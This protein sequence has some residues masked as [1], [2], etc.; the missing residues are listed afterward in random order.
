M[1]NLLV[2]LS[3]LVSID[4]RTSMGVASDAAQRQLIQHTRERLGRYVLMAMELAVL[5]P[6]GHMDTPEGRACLDR[7]GLL[8]PGEWEAMVAGDRHTT[9]LCWVQMICV[10][11]RRR[12]LLHETEVASPSSTS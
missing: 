9:V 4:D 8:A 11:L 12:G 1:R 2:Q 6:R 7:L 5:K 10:S 3:T